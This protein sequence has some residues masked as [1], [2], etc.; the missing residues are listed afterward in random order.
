M[1]AIK[2]P[3][4]LKY[5][6]SEEV[7]ALFSKS[8]KSVDIC[9]DYNSTTNESDLTDIWESSAIDSDSSESDPNSQLSTVVDPVTDYGNFGSLSDDTGN[10]D[11]SSLPESEPK[12]SSRQLRPRK[13]PAESVL[14]DQPRRKKHSSDSYSLQLRQGSLTIL[15]K[16]NKL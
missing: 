5:L 1:A 4:T 9:S 10:S 12:Q 13:R 16:I 14:P 8:R 15:V 3:G 11:L 6:T 2:Q 7:A